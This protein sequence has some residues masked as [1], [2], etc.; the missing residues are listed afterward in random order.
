MHRQ[1]TLADFIREACRRKGVSL[2]EASQAMGRS[3]NWLERVANYDPEAG[4]GIRRPRVEGCKDIARYFGEDPN[5]ILQLAGYLSP[6]AS[7]TPI[8]DEIT[9]I[10]SF[11]P[12]KEQRALLEHAKLLKFRVSATSEPPHFPDVGIDWDR[13]D[14]IFAR[15]LAAFIHDEPATVPIWIDALNSLPEKAVEFLLMN[16][17]NQ[18]VLRDETERDQAAQILTRLAH[19]LI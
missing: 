15:E 7:P 13:L 16:A 8:V 5:Y 1:Q 14:P 4:T 9:S 17:K 10:A 19:S 11:L 18:V 12:H 6:P 2:G 3:R